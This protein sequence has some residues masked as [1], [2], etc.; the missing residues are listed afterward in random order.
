MANSR[1][2]LPTQSDPSQNKPG[3]R[4]LEWALALTIVILTWEATQK[5]QE[6]KAP[7]QQH[8]HFYANIGYIQDPVLNIK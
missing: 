4:G 1:P 6:F 7:P 5:D 2:A 3:G 8:I